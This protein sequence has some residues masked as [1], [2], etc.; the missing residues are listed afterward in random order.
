M[1]TC[2]KGLTTTGFSL[3]RAVSLK[4]ALLAATGA[5]LCTLV[6]RALA[7]QLREGGA[8]E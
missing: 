6:W 4:L 3:E 7:P 8:R 2:W 5:G 1:R